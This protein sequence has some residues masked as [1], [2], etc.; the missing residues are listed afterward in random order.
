VRGGRSVV[1]GSLWGKEN[2][3]GCKREVKEKKMEQKLGGRG[4]AASG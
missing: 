3:D 2:G 4:V 1:A